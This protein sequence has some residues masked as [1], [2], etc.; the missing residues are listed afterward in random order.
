MWRWCLGDDVGLE[1]GLRVGVSGELGWGQE[2]QAV[3]LDLWQGTG[4]ADVGDDALL[5]KQG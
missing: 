1:V 5:A 2:D 4:Q 3:C